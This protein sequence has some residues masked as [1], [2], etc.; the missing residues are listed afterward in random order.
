MYEKKTCLAQLYEKKPCLACLGGTEEHWC[1]FVGPILAIQLKKKHFLTKMWALAGPNAIYIYIYTCQSLSLSLALAYFQPG[2]ERPLK[3]TYIIGVPE[4]KFFKSV[5]GTF[6][7]YSSCLIFPPSFPFRPCPLSCPF[8]LFHLPLYHP[9][10]ASRKNLLCHS[11][12][13]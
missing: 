5:F 3:N 6:S 9:F 11:K 13:E 7:S 10:H 2:F 4:S 8:S 12:P 1:R